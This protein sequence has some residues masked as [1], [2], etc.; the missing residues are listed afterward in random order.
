MTLFGG[1]V[2][3]ILSTLDVFA[4]AVLNSFHSIQHYKTSSRRKL[5][6]RIFKKFICF[7]TH[8]V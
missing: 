3:Q 2:G 4:Q 1:T 8:T 5:V 6:E 7:H